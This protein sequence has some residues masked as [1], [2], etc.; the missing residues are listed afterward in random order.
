[1]RGCA[2]RLTSRPHRPSAG[3]SFHWA[4]SSRTRRRSKQKAVELADQLA[5]NA[6]ETNKLFLNSIAARAEIGEV[7]ASWP[8]SR[9]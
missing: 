1:M 7:T 2:P 9:R 4:C 8:S 5:S 6:L 3:A